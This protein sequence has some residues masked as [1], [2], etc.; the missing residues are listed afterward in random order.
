MANTEKK[1]VLDKTIREL[2]KWHEDVHGVII[3]PR[4]R[5]LGLVFN[6]SFRKFGAEDIKL[7]DL[8]PRI[9]KGNNNR[10]CLDG[11]ELDSIGRIQSSIFFEMLKMAGY[12]VAK[13]DVPVPILKDSYSTWVDQENLRRE[14]DNALAQDQIRNGLRKYPSR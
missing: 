12:T 5:D 9:T 3:R 8:L 11:K 10:L 13:G 4:K 7:K 2:T 14:L 1:S 6:T